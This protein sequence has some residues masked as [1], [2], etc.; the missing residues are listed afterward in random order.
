MGI[1][2]NKEF[3]PKDRR[4]MPRGPRD[5]QIKQYHDSD[6]SSMSVILE[7]TKNVQ[8][9]QEKLDKSVSVQSGFSEEQLNDEIEKAIKEEHSLANARF[10]AEKEVLQNKIIALEKEISSLKESKD[11]EILS[12]KEI[13]KNKNDIIEQIKSTNN[14][15]STVSE[16]KIANMLTEAT[17]KIESVALASMHLSGNTNQI[18]VDRPKMEAVFVDPIEKEVEVEKHFEVDVEDVSITKKED[19]AGKVDK[20]KDRKSVV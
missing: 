12:L 6:D 7:L 13:I 8:E 19:M 4:V 18:A 2:Y 1:T 16:E 15:L 14:N 5:R 9:L 17:K 10:N 20:L 11:N 3:Q